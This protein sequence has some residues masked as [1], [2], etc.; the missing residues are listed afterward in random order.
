MGGSRAL[1]RD[2]GVLTVAQVGAQLLNVVALVVIARQVGDHWFGV[3]QLGVAVSM[4][5]LIA[6]EWGLFSLGVRAVSRLSG[7]A[8]VRDYVRGHAGLMHLLAFAV[9]AAGLLLTPLLPFFASDPVVFVLYLASVLPQAGMLAWVGIG[10]ERMTWVGVSKVVRSLLYA[11]GILLLLPRAEGL[12]GW[13]AHRWVPVV[14]L[15]SFLF[16]NV[17]MGLPVFR[18]LGGPFLPALGRWRE[19]GR[20]LAETGAIG[21][22]NLVRRVLLNIDI[23]MLGIL[24]TPALAGVYAAAAKLVFVLVMVV[25]LS[26]S[27]MLPRLSRLWKESHAT[28]R[29]AFTNYLGVL[30]ACLAPVAVGGALVADP[31]LD[32]VYAGRFPGSGTVFAVLSVSYVLL[33]LGMY[34]GNALIAC[35]RQRASFPPL[36]VAAVVAV[37]GN[38]LLAPRWGA[39]GSAAAMLLAHATLAAATLWLCRRLLGRRLVEFAAI[40]A[41]GCLVMALAVAA[42]APLHPYLRVVLG[43][44]VYAGVAGPP[45]WRLRGRPAS[46]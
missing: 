39:A 18:W 9:L 37:A 44:V 31:L 3:L 35:D 28:F 26:L 2:I 11:V 5:A 36:A 15:V 25:E 12:A 17:V 41:G 29:D 30:F 8:A 33:C 7:A 20:M 16:S 32:A 13:P 43:A 38:L 21:G 4:Y 1:L 14:F 23:V 34:F 46:A 27:A 10:L 42:A 24:A 22:G 6:A 19:S 40:A 45:L